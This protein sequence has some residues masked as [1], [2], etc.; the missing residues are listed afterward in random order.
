MTLGHDDGL[1]VKRPSGISPASIVREGKD[2]PELFFLRGQVPP[3]EGIGAPGRPGPGHPPGSGGRPSEPQGGRPD[4]NP[5]GVPRHPRDLQHR[6]QALHHLRR[7]GDR[8]R[9]SGRAAP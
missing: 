7:Q 4:V 2:R 8:R 9:G 3:A 1:R 5:G 6:R